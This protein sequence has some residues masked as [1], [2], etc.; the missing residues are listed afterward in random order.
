MEKSNLVII[1]LRVGE[2]QPLYELFLPI[3]NMII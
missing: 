1:I 3:I 2:K